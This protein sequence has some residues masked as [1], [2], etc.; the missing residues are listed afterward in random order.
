M[1]SFVILITFLSLL[2]CI[3]CQ[4]T[5]NET[6]EFDMEAM[7]SDDFEDD[8]LSWIYGLDGWQPEGEFLGLTEI[9]IERAEDISHG[10]NDSCRGISLVNPQLESLYFGDSLV[11]KEQ[12]ALLVLDYF[13]KFCCDGYEEVEIHTDNQNGFTLQDLIL[14]T[15]ATYL[16]RY[17]QDSLNVVDAVS[18][19]K[20]LPMPSN[21]ADSLDLVIW[22]ACGMESFDMYQFLCYQDSIGI[23]R[24]YIDLW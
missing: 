15:S 19:S 21:V 16:D 17:H 10:M 6:E 13:P 9:L 3:G 5:E 7:E 2:S 12:T 22:S 23:N 20:Q 1:K 18:R 8:T 11:L 14:I 4:N 24:I